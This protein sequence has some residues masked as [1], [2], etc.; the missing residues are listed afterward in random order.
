M[1]KSVQSHRENLA[2][3]QVNCLS[4][5]GGCLGSHRDE[6]R[7]GFRYGPSETQQIVELRVR[8]AS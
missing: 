1:G 5:S 8:K 6:G 2:S 3:Q 7:S 4:C